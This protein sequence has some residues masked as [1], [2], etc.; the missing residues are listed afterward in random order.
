MSCSSSLSKSQ[1]TCVQEQPSNNEKESFS[2]K[3]SSEHDLESSSE[4]QLKEIVNSWHKK[5][6]KTD[7]KLLEEIEKCASE[8]IP[9]V[10]HINDVVDTHAQNYKKSIEGTDIIIQALTENDAK[11]DMLKNLQVSGDKMTFYDYTVTSQ[12]NGMHMLSQFLKND[13]QTKAYSFEEDLLSESTGSLSI[14]EPEVQQD[15]KKKL[16]ATLKAIDNGDN[17]VITDV[18]KPK[19]DVMKE[20]FG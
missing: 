18:K 11:N 15:D 10:Q 5:N 16:L 17:L 9:T 2:S 1:Y 19:C 6:S 20:L 4:V 12:K 14:T 7:D 13:S 3:S 8:V